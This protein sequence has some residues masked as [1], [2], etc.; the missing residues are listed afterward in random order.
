MG[1][2]SAYFDESG[3]DASNRVAVVAGYVGS[4]FQWRRFCKRWDVALSLENVKIMHRSDLE[5]FQGEFTEAKGWC[6]T[7]RNLFV[8]KFQSIIKRHTYS[9]V[10]A[11]VVKKDFNLVMP[12]WVG[13]LFGGV[14]GWCAF[15]C[16]VA[17]RGWCEE[18]RHSERINWTFESGSEVPACEIDEMFR[19]LQLP[20]LR[21][22]YRIGSVTFDTKDLKP[23][24]AADVVAYE[25][26]KHT[27]NQVLDSGAMRKKRL[28]ALDLFR[29]Q[30]EPYSTFWDKDRMNGWLSDCDRDKPFGDLT[31]SEIQRA[32]RRK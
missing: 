25:V 30:D 6:P 29:E 14:Y 8:P 17:M 31:V 12:P 13:S 21:D 5:N 2:L 9:A 11:A 1:M 23:L 3:T 32:L 22:L 20:D 26:F 7:R 4:D 19:V 15:M 18:R 10:S 27:E 16:V 28:S 24:Q